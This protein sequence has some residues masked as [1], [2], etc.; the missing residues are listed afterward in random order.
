[1]TVIT[2]SI[3]QRHGYV[4]PAEVAAKVNAVDIAA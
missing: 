4:S 2:L 1:M 3:E